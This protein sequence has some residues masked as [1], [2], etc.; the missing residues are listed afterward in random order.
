[1]TGKDLH[2]FTTLEDIHAV[3]QRKALR[4]VMLYHFCLRKRILY[5][6]HVLPSDGFGVT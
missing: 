5:R 1:V 2:I 3:L 4:K 6:R